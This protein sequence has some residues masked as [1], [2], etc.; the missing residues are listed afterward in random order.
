MD[1][2]D[3]FSGYPAPKLKT[4]L[5]VGDDEGIGAFLV[6]TLMMETNYR[7]LLATTSVQALE[8]VKTVMPD[9]F[10][11]DYQLP[12]MDGLELADCLQALETFKHLPILLMS[13][14]LPKRAREMQHISFIEKPFD[15]DELLQR[16]ASLLGVS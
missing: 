3:H 5:V 16:V 4:I 13:A 10:L 14:N 11:L 8:I 2:M 7:A 15:L 1:D 12:G 9:L 6:T